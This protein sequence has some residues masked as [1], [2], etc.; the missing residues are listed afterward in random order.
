MEH[1]VMSRPQSRAP[2][3]ARLPLGLLFGQELGDIL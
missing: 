1:A 3:S 2:N